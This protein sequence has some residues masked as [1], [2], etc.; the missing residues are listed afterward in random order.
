MG[1]RRGHID[2]ESRCPRTSK[3]PLD[4]WHG[5]VVGMHLL[6]RHDMPFQRVDE[7]PQQPRALARALRVAFGRLSKKAARPIGAARADANRLGQADCLD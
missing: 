5:D 7:R 6:A 4:Y 3:F 1:G 2:P